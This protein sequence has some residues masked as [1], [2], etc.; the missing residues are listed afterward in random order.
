MDAGNEKWGDW[1]VKVTEG[2][3]MLNSYL[4]ISLVCCVR[5]VRPISVICMEFPKFPLNLAYF[6][7]SDAD[8]EKTVFADFVD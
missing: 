4:L 7:A 5:V 8:Y 2:L 6:S 1:A 3:N